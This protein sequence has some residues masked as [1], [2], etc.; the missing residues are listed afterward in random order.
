MP[1]LTP[2]QLIEKYKKLPKDV[3]ESY[4]G[5]DTAD[6]LQRIAKEN[7]LN[8][9]KTGVLADEVG[10]FMLGITTPSQFMPN[11]AGRLGIGK[12]AAKKIGQEINT[13]IFVKV[14]E[15]LKKIHNIGQKANSQEE[16][17]KQ[18]RPFPDQSAQPGK[19][20][21]MLI[22]PH[23]SFDESKEPELQIK[24]I[25]EA[26]LDTPKQNDQISRS[27]T[28]IVEKQHPFKTP[29]IKEL[30]PVEKPK[31]PK[32]IDPYREPTE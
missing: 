21:P 7:G 4:F 22:E 27:K 17:P 31:Y 19:K 28:E 9:E 24:N 12:D 15:S 18:V 5:V 13:Q 32:G 23:R 16:I 20:E 29:E 2:E 8:V 26:I 10:L 25:E 14:R 1:T 6:V 30:K 3:Q 11:L